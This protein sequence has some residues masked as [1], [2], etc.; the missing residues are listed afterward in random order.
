MNYVSRYWSSVFVMLAATGLSTPARAAL[1][2][3]SYTGN[4]FTE[5]SAGFPVSRVSIWFTVDD[6]L[7]P[8]NGHVNLDSYNAKNLNEYYFSNGYQTLSNNPNDPFFVYTSASISFDTDAE[9]NIN[10]NWNA[11]SSRAHGNQDGLIL[12]DSIEST[13]IKDKTASLGG[14]GASVTNNPGTWTRSTST[15]PLPDGFLLFGSA[16][17]CL[18]FRRAIRRQPESVC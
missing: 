6:T 16:L 10:G 1:V 18:G 14:Y 3:Y 17:A 2:Q 11:T 7:I 13:N 5:I 4:P 15:V 12:S 8:I 9:G